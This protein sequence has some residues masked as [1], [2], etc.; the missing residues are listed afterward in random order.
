MFSPLVS[1]VSA[2][3]VRKVGGSSSDGSKKQSM[4][5]N[6]AK[7]IRKKHHLHGPTYYAE[8]RQ[9]QKSQ[10]ALT[11]RPFLRHAD[12]GVWHP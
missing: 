2:V 10:P 12:V 3:S 9:H 11:F 6:G 7:K 1:A 8:T 4:G 5:A